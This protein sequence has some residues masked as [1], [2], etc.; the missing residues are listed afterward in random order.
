MDGAMEEDS[1]MIKGILGRRFDWTKR[2]HI[3]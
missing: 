2:P 1:P 3:E